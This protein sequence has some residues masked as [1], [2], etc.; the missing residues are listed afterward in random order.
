M[1]R[2]TRLLIATITVSAIVLLLL[3]RLRFPDRPPIAAAPV[4]PLERL[5]ARATYDELAGIV[6][7]V[8]RLIAPSLVVL[9]LAPREP[10]GPRVLDDVLAAPADRA[11][12]HVA[13]LRIDRTTAVAAVDVGSRILDVIGGAPGGQDVQIV[14]ADPVRRIALVRVPATDADPA[15][16]VT[17]TDLQTPTYVV[18][19][20]GTRAGLT[21][22]PVFVGSSDR[23]ADPRWPRPLL[24]VSSVALTSPGALIFSLEGQFLGFAIV[25]G[26]TLGIVGARDIVA[27]AEQLGAGAQRTPIDAGIS[28]QPLTPALAA[29]LGATAGVVVA[30]VDARGPAAGVL[31]PADVVTVVD[32]APV[33]SPD[34]FLVRLAQS[35]PGQS[36]ALTVVRDGQARTVT[37]T[38]PGGAATAPA[39]QAAA[40]TLT[41]QRGGSLVE[42]V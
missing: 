16:H 9:R 32:N 1:S 10:S 13:A 6:A 37:M 38:L 4:A 28:V 33:D 30:D 3:S 29:A 8:E 11:M 34:D 41:A 12:Q 22:R 5:A 17:L 20:E 24:A 36:L 21:F 42:T 23:F 14:A 19:A 40:L 18:V 26:G 7:R 27:A 25:E 31:L 39:R 35:A 15:H 2:E